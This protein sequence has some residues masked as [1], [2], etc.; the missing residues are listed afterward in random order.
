MQCYQVLCQL[1]VN[2]YISRVNFPAHQLFLLR[3]IC[4]TAAIDGIKVVEPKII[5]MKIIQSACVFFASV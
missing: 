4:R 3:I 2:F 5:N 1:L